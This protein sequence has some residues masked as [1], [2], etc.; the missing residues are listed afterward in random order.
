MDRLTPSQAPVGQS[1]SNNM[2]AFQQEQREQQHPTMTH[3]VNPPS[4]QHGTAGV[5]SAYSR[6]PPQGLHDQS[7][8]LPAYPRRQEIPG[9]EAMERDGPLEYS[10]TSGPRK[11]QLIAAKKPGGQAYTGLPVMRPAYLHSLP[12]HA[13][14]MP[15][16]P[17]LNFTLADLFVFLPI[18]FKSIPIAARA[19][20]NGVSSNVHFEILQEHRVLNIPEAELSRLKD[21]ISANY[22][23]TMR[24]SD[25]KWTKASHKAPEG[26][27]A[28]DVSVGNFVPDGVIGSSFPAKL[29]VPLSRPI[30]FKDLMKDVTR[31]PS[32][33]DAGDLT[34][35]VEF[36]IN[37]QKQGSDGEVSDWIFPDDIHTILNHI[38]YTNITAQ[39]MDAA[40]VVRYSKIAREV[41]NADRKRRRELEAAGHPAPAPK[42]RHV[43]K[44]KVSEQVVSRAD[45]L[46]LMPQPF[47]QNVCQH[48]Q[49]LRPLLPHVPTAVQAPSSNGQYGV[50]VPPA[51][52][53]TEPT[54][55]LKHT[56]QAENSVHNSNVALPDGQDLEDSVAPSEERFDG[57]E[58]IFSFGMEHAEF[59]DIDELISGHQEYDF[60]D[61]FSPATDSHFYV[62]VDDNIPDV[63]T[64]DSSLRY[65]Y[66]H[67]LRD[68]VEADDF[69]DFS[70]LAR[71]A[72]WCRN[73]EN[74]ASHY[75]VSDAYF[76]VNL[77]SMMEDAE[78]Y[79]SGA[80]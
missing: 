14:I 76:V 54:P 3:S 19:L 22:R 49:V 8:T 29:P 56:V 59:H 10:V 58:Q 46:G 48:D 80:T 5:E 41:A 30:P 35:A 70:D 60:S 32:G 31:L 2:H 50:L 17:T 16:G 57:A 28:D 75:S 37:N 40:V 47:S 45:V 42:R 68:C 77:M 51:I 25:T 53:V 34:R 27:N 79:V 61:L 18:W 21:V 67:P 43:A 6:N 69:E 33:P 71:T 62:E 65:S 12:E 13:Y 23:R 11:D 66:D 1:M 78:R 52:T 4:S 38:G 74:L 55:P 36:A 15:P 72:R 7:P 73:P 63:T 26:W 20:N 44:A 24:R 39:H 64:Q 9:S